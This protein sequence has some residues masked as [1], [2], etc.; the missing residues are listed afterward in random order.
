L[1]LDGHPPQP[2]P[3]PSSTHFRWRPHRLF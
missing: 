2:L 3:P 1:P